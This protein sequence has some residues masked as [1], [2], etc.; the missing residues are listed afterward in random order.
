MNAGWRLAA[1]AVLAG[2]AAML[3]WLAGTEPQA[4]SGS[5]A[6]SVRSAPDV[7]DRRAASPEGTAA[8]SVPALAE[9]A[10]PLLRQVPPSAVSGAVRIAGRVLRRGDDAPLDGVVVL[11]IADD[12][13][14]HEPAIVGE[15]RTAAGAFELGP[16]LVAR[17]PHTLHF[18]WHRYGGPAANPDADPHPPDAFL[19]M[20][21]HAP[22]V[23]VALRLDQVTAPLDALEVWIE[24]G[25]IARGRIVDGEGRSVHGVEVHVAGE[26]SRLFALP[27][28]SDAEGRFTLG[29]LDPAR[30]LVLR[31][32]HFGE[33]VENLS[34][35]VGPPTDGWVRDLGDVQ[36]PYR[37]PDWLR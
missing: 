20:T 17:G 8:A 21:V 2:T 23:D 18:R 33:P 3:A 37:V 11:V 34:R 19:D 36:L 7:R 35:E 24:T 25:W 15:L 27:H 10:Q 29:D 31:F 5:V 16:E 22:A 9:P 30:N 14:L 28:S 32:R 1:V 13:R 6:P 26:A 4:E 12:P